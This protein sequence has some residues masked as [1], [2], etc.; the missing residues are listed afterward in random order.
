MFAQRVAR[1]PQ[2]PTKERIAERAGAAQDR[3]SGHST[4]EEL[5]YSGA[6]NQATLHLQPKLAVGTVND[7]LER[8]AGLRLTK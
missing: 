6:S 2:S 7:P 3:Q 1:A 5:Q 8:E 4:I